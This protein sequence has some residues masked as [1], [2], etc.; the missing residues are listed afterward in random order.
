MNVKVIITKK[1][2][3]ESIKQ[4]YCCTFEEADQIEMYEMIDE[5]LMK[6]K[7]LSKLQKERILFLELG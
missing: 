5:K 6:L 2:V 7:N 1:E 3:V 4:S